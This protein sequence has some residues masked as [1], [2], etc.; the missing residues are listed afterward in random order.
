MNSSLQRGIRIESAIFWIDSRCI[1]KQGSKRC[2]RERYI[3]CRNTS[4]ACKYKLY[5][6]LLQKKWNTARHKEIALTHMQLRRSESAMPLPM[7]L[8]SSTKPAATRSFLLS[9]TELTVV[10]PNHRFYVALVWVP[11]IVKRATYFQPRLL[12]GVARI[13]IR[14]SR[15][16]AVESMTGGGVQ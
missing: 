1:R 7:T 13:S 16:A 15:G 3:G 4:L 8:L 14:G 10:S 12:W 11:R 2:I 6:R 5:S 9:V